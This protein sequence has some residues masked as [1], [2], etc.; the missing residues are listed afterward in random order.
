[1]LNPSVDFASLVYCILPGSPRFRLQKMDRG[2]VLLRRRHWAAVI[3]DRLAVFMDDALEAKGTAIHVRVIKP[4][5]MQPT[6]GRL[7]P[8]A[9][10][11]EEQGK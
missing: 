8:E 7:T 3:P 4:P 1:M 2:V 10:V 9:G 5:F 11:A 6:D